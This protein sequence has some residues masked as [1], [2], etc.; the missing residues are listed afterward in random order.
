MSDTQL[1]MKYQSYF[2]LID[3][4][5][6]QR[7]L[8][9]LYKGKKRNVDHTFNPFEVSQQSMFENVANVIFKNI[10]K[11]DMIKSI[12]RNDNPLHDHS[13]V[14]AI[15]KIDESERKVKN[16][17]Y[18]EK[19]ALRRLYAHS[20]QSNDLPI[21]GKIIDYEF[22][23]SLDS[24]SGVGEIDLISYA[25]DSNTIF[26]IEGKTSNNNE[27]ILRAILEIETYSRILLNQKDSKPSDY[28]LRYFKE[29]DI[30]IDFDTVKFEKVILF[31]NFD[32]TTASKS[33]KKWRDISKY[34]STKALV[35][36]F[37]INIYKIVEEE[38][39]NTKG[40]IGVYPIEQIYTP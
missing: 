5:A 1:D 24:D 28:F 32:K 27:T 10:D 22:P 4:S 37:K 23:L 3:S 12:K 34:P 13:V 15:R 14:E 19:I 16:N 18:H 30:S 26:L 6:A 35:D 21:L 39:F 33:E 40:G 2:D 29:K 36:N 7:S 9:Y 20:Q 25:K 17:Y 8:V 11:F 38:A 31:F